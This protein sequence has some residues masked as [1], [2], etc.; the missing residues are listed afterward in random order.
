MGGAKCDGGV[1]VHEVVSGGFVCRIGGLQKSPP[2]NGVISTQGA[3]HKEA[4]NALLA[5]QFSSQR[6]AAVYQLFGSSSEG[7]PDDRH[8]T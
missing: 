8:T 3:R 4:L 2:L 6:M 1:A 5:M 7:R